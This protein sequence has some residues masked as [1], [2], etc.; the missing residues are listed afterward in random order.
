MSKKSPQEMFSQFIKEQNLEET[1]LK[2]SGIDSLDELHPKNFPELTSPVAPTIMK[3]STSSSTVPHPSLP[4]SAAD[5]TERVK[6][7]VASDMI[8]P[9]VGLKINYKAKKAPSSYTPSSLMMDYIVHQINNLLVDNFYFKRACPDYHPYILRLYYGMIFWVQCLRAG[10]H[11]RQI[12]IDAHVA[13]TS[14]LDAFPLETLPIS[15]P[16]LSL[17]KTLC[18]SQPEIP[19][20]GVVYPKC[21]STPG[22]ERRDSFIAEGVE[23]HV[24]PN[25]PGIFALLSDLNQRLNPE[26]AAQATYPA[27]GK[28]F[29]VTAAAAAATIFG[30]H[31]FPVHATRTARQKWSLV[32][33]GLQYPCEADKKLHENFAERYENF[34]FP[35]LT[36]ADDLS[37]F[38]SFLHIGTN[39]AW[40]AQVRDVAA[41]EA[42]FF[43]GSGTLADCAPF[44]VASNQVVVHYTAPDTAPAA[45]T[46]SADPA[47]LFPFALR[48]KTSSRSLPELAEA[49]A[50]FAQTNIQMFGTHPFLP[51]FGTAQRVG[52]FWDIRPEETSIK[53]DTS[54]L[55]LREIIRGLM[56]TKG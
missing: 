26:D 50:A 5:A 22:P 30:H 51:N 29:P 13:L 34:C 44:G 36:D 7:Q 55:S 6:P 18:C 11:A 53:D 37:P 10:L 15:G 43:E 39:M 3:P 23:H 56:K 27:K 28:H 32:S 20:Y 40:F 47:S 21:P 8:R 54:F 17:F 24:M 33:S 41:V 19:T 31:S 14:F 42:S 25:I 48:L 49:M 12:E 38:P 46:R 4:K 1:F 52:P 9:Y 16:L 45:P 2:A 35:T